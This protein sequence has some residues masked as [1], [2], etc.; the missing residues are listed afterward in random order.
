MVHH[1]GLSKNRNLKSNGFIN[2]Y[3]YLIHGIF[4]IKPPSYG[5]KTAQLFHLT[6]EIGPELAGFWDRDRVQ[7]H[8]DHFQPTSTCVQLIFGCP[9]VEWNIQSP[10]RW[11]YSDLSM[12]R[13][14]CS[15]LSSKRTYPKMQSNNSERMQV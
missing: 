8:R 1:V 12:F 3:H 2:I 10:F 11:N 9:H 13:A 5:A 14:C 6:A 7:G 4:P 15:N